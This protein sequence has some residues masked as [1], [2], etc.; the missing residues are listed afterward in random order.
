V[1]APLFGGDDGG[2]EL[3]FKL[4]LEFEFEFAIECELEFGIL[5]TREAATLS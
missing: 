1:N 2:G 4:G 5:T 3:E